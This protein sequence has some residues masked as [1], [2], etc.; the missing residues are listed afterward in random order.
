MRTL[1]YDN[2]W[3]DVT[4][5]MALADWRD[6]GGVKVAMNR[7]YELNGRLVQEVQF[8][9]FQANSRSTPRGSQ[10]RRS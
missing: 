5:D 10:C 7:K 8:T 9:D 2:V 4:Y 6:F 3:G 1:D